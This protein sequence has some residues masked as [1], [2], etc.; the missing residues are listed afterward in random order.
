MNLRILFPYILALIITLPCCNK[1]EDPKMNSEN[2]LSPV[3][4]IVG[5]DLE[6]NGTAEDLYISF[7]NDPANDNIAEFQIYLSESNN[8]ELPFLLGLNDTHR[9]IHDQKT[10]TQSIQL[11]EDLLDTNG[12]PIAEENFYFIYIIS[13]PATSTVEPVLAISINSVALQQTH[14]VR[15]LVNSVGGGSGG[16]ELDQDGNIYMSDFGQTLQGPAGDKVFRITPDGVVSTFMTNLI[17]A[18]GNSFDSQGNFYQSNIQGGSIT[19]RSANGEIVV[20]PHSLLNAPVGIAHDMDDNLYIANYGSN[21]IIKMTPDGEFSVYAGGGLLNG[22]N[23]I[24]R[25]SIGNFYVAN[26]NNGDVIKV[27]TNKNITRVTTLPGGNNGHLIL[28]K[29]WLYVIDRGGHRI[30]RV[31]P[32]GHQEVLVGSGKRGH[33]D[34]PP[35]IAS[36]SLPNDLA[37][38]PDGKKLYFNDVVPLSGN[39]ISPCK[40]KYVELID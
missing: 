40:I 7:I 10:Q 17:G 27:D 30:Y 26:F 16:M 39:N 29:E 14:L 8:L 38:T 4:G 28:H 3:T 32:N 23:G 33:Q 5:H 11:K 15:T 19:R 35:S 21:N 9:H 22:P 36:L 6:N 12:D 2:L 13:I 34:G 1:P 24:A 31:R 37:I 20:F 25:D 18:S